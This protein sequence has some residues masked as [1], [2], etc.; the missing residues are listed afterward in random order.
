MKR[1]EDRSIAPAGADEAIRQL[2]T[3]LTRASR[4]LV[5]HDARTREEVAEMVS[6]A[7]AQF[8]DLPR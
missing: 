5:S 1:K 3:L 7:L 6:A 2:K 4:L 8:E